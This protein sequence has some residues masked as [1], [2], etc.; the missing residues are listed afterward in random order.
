M[1]TYLPIRALNRSS[2]I[3]INGQVVLPG[4]TSY[5]DI[6]IA[7]VRKDLADHSTLGQIFVVGPITASNSDGV[8]TSAGAGAVTPG[9]GVSVNVAAGELKVQSTGA[10]VA[11]AAATNQALTLTTSAGQS[12]VFG[13]NWD[14]TAGTVSVTAGTPATTGSQVAPAIPAGVTRLATVTLANGA[15]SVITGNI[16][17]ARGRA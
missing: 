3:R 16:V 9:T 10:F 4:A 6:S 12:Q 17:D 14:N 5:V 1:A 8:V 15:A 7:S 11:G 2:R 13:I